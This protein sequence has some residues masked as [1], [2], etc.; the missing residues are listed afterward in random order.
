MKNLGKIWCLIFTKFTQVWRICS[1]ARQFVVVQKFTQV[2]H[3]GKADLFVLVLIVVENFVGIHVN[4]CRKKK[5]NVFL[6]IHNISIIN[7]VSI[8][9]ANF[10]ENANIARNRIGTGAEHKKLYVAVVIR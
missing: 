8:R 5:L 3:K 9:I 1:L 7:Q 10:V 6:K 2:C 4:D